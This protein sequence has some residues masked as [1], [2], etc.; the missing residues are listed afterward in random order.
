MNRS[1]TVA[2]TG[3]RSYRGEADEAL[4]ATI[5]RLYEAGFTSFMSGMASGFDL[6][7]AEAVVRLREELPALRLVAVVPYAKQTSR[8]GVGERLRYQELLVAADERIILSELFYKGCFQV[9]NRYLVEHAAA[10]VAWYNGTTGGT[11][12]TFLMALHRG[13]QI[14]NLGSIGLDQRLF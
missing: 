12:H 14:E 2:F 1:T 6:A 13:L 3:H 7:A 11:Q 4:Y 9:R 10:L 5:R 8:Y